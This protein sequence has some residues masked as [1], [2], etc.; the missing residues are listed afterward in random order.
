MGELGGPGTF[1]YPRLLGIAETWVTADTGAGNQLAN[2]ITSE[3]V[4][5]ALPA[6][7]SLFP[8]SPLNSMKRAKKHTLIIW[9]ILIRSRKQE[10]IKILRRQGDIGVG[11]TVWHRSCLYSIGTVYICVGNMYRRMRVGEW[12]G[13]SGKGTQK[14][15]KRTRERRGGLEV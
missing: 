6:T 7:P 15:Q 10:I 13:G 14:D 9:K 1:D 12:M 2:P 11:R 5:N 4:T 8:Q 3:L